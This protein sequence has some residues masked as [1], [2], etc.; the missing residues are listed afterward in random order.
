M[1][2]YYAITIGRQL[3]SGGKFIGER[4]AQ[5]LNIPCYDKELIHLAAQESGLEKT[6]FEKVDEKDSYSFM[7]KYFGFRSG[8]MGYS[9]SNYLCNETLFQIQSDVIRKIAERESAIFVGRCADYIL[10]EHPRCLKVFMFSELNDRVARIMSSMNLSQA[11]AAALIARI[12]K[13]RA[14][15]YNYYSQKVW[16]M[17][18]SYDL[19]FNSSKI[20]FERIVAVVEEYVSANFLSGKPL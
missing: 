16:G 17:A 4:L 5:R 12:D 3:G 10:R 20:D 8:F 14:S 13:K 15:Y 1:E 18:A 11:D 7:G 19:C 2:N 9:E 6:L